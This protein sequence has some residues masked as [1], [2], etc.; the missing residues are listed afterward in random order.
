PTA[1]ERRRG[2]LIG[3]LADGAPLAELAAATGDRP[4]TIREIAQREQAS[5]AAAHVDRRGPRAGRGA[6]L[7]PA[8]LGGSAPGF[9]VPRCP[10]LATDP[11]LSDS[12]RVI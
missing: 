9:P 6:P 10:R 8:G 4:G 1:A 11:L 7:S 2:H 12:F 5:G 3:R